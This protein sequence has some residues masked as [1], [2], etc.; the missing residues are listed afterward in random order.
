MKDTI[1]F[2]ETFIPQG[3]ENCPMK[4]STVVVA[5]SSPIAFRSR[6]HVLFLG[7]NPGRKEAIF[8]RPFVGPAGLLLRSAIF[9]KL[10]GFSTAFSNV[11]L[12]STPNERGIPDIENV[13]S[14]CRPNIAAI[15]RFFLPKIYV[16]CGTSA[17]RAIGIETGNM[18]VNSGRVFKV[19]SAT[20]IPIIHPSAI[21][22]GFMS[23]DIFARDMGRIAYEL[24]RMS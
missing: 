3:C 24:R 20:V 10:Q 23:R 12:C 9:E 8:G 7:V 22:R 17:M 4:G 18:T 6:V 13:F 21:L 19:K 15:S 11:I 16:P 2:R 1:K 14:H 5:D